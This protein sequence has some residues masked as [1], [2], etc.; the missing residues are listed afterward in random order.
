MQE[1]Y[2]KA[3]ERVGDARFNDKPYLMVSLR[4]TTMWDVLSSEGRENTIQYLA[5]AMSRKEFLR[6]V[7]IDAAIEYCRKAGLPE[8]RNAEDIAELM[9]RKDESKCPVCGNEI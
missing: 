8:D 6:D 2:F 4:G 1:I 7:V 3:V 5:E 9:M